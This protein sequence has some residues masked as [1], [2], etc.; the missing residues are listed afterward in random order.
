MFNKRNITI[1]VV[2]VALILTSCIRNP[3]YPGREFIPDMAHSKAYEGYFENPGEGILYEGMNAQLPPKGSIAQSF[4]VYPF[5]NTPEGYETAG[6]QFFNEFTFTDAELSGEGKKLF[7]RFCA[8]CH[9]VE[10]DGKG[11]LTTLKLAMSGEGFPQPPSYFRED[12]LIL[13]QGKRYHTVM[14][15]K[16]MMG[17]YATQLSHRERWL[18]LSYVQSLQDKYV[19]A[20]AKTEETA[21]NN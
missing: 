10:G 7:E 19:A 16:G 1:V 3:K 21:S 17:S 6:E 12:I 13:P 2:L 8:I 4:E 5:P 11:H 20:N 9:G 15:G 14:Y 18:V